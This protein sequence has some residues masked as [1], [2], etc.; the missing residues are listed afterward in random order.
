MSVVMSKTQFAM[1]R[2][3]DNIKDEKK[4]DSI[5]KREMIKKRMEQKKQEDNQLE[6]Q[7]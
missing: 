1:K 5:K 2:N 3:R 7:G 6:K 4:T